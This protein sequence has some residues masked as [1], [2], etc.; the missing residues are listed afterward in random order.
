MHFIAYLSTLLVVVT[1]KRKYFYPDVGKNKVDIWMTEA[2]NITVDDNFIV[3]WMEMAVDY[4]D[5]TPW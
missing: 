5:G 4:K 3:E 2:R 1:A